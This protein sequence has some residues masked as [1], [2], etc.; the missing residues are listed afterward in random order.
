MLPSPETICITASEGWHQGYHC[1]DSYS[2]LAVTSCIPLE[3]GQLD[4]LLPLSGSATTVTAWELPGL[5]SCAMRWI[6]CTCMCDLSAVTYG[7]VIWDL[8]FSKSR[9]TVLTSNLV[10]ISQRIFSLPFPAL[11]LSR[12]FLPFTSHRAHRASWTWSFKKI[13]SQRPTSCS[14]A[15][16]HCSPVPSNSDSPPSCFLL[17]A[18][19]GQGPFLFHVRTAMR[20]PGRSF[21]CKHDEMHLWF[22]N[23]LS[24]VQEGRYLYLLFFSFFLEHTT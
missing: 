1:Y 24:G 13:P 17:A 14:L 3:T 10:F 21:F 4:S 23:I 9:L 15:K 20:A 2:I 8:A 16:I 6:T 22:W 11:I 5:Q 7:T 12:H 19:L 18:D